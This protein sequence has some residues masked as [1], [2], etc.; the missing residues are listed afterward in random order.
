MSTQKDELAPGTPVKADK[1]ARRSSLKHDAN[2]AV[3]SLK[4]L[5]SKRVMDD[6]ANRYGIRTKDKVFGVPVGKI[7]QLGK[8]MTRGGRERDHELAEALW[9]TGVYEG[10]M[11]AAFVADPAKVTPAEMDRWVKTFDNWGIC[12][13]VCFKLWD[14]SPHAWKKAAQWARSPREYIRRTGFVLM[15]CLALHEKNAGD[16]PFAKFLPLI[17]K[18]ATDDRNFV[19]K[20]V[21]WALRSIGRRR[22]GLRK[23]SVAVA[24]RLAE[25][26]DAAAR[27]VGKDALRDLAKGKTK[28]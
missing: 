23:A 24:R 21:S 8:S 11:L 15:A 12:D 5:G 14:Q 16:E 17:E 26:D 13:T 27:W 19:K 20:G 3:A 22:A 7:Q 4:R 25:S 10:R 9:Q 18:G 6:M 1:L 28:A 2:A